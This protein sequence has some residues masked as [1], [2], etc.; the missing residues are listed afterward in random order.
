MQGMVVFR[1]VS[2]STGGLCVV[3]RTNNDQTQRKLAIEYPW[4][5]SSAEDWLELAEDDEHQARKLLVRPYP[6]LNDLSTTPLPSLPSRTASVS[7]FVAL[8]STHVAPHCHLCGLLY[9]LCIIFVQVR[10]KAGDMILWDSRTLHCGRPGTREMKDKDW[11]RL[12]RLALCVSMMPNERVSTETLKA[13][14]HAHYNCTTLTHWANHV[15]PHKLVGE[16]Q[17]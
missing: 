15:R 9:F 5:A 6:T 4:L 3:P 17:V 8:A 1:D 11:G 10:A 16:L 2:E 12:S 13:R 7:K 14:L